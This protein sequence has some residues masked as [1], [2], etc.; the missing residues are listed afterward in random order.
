MRY[1]PIELQGEILRYLPEIALNA[2]SKTCKRNSNLATPLL[3]RKLAINVRLESAT[4]SP[5]QKIKS[6]AAN[7]WDKCRYLRSIAITCR[8]S[9]AWLLKG[10]DMLV[11][12]YILLIHLP[13]TGLISFAWDVGYSF[14]PDIVR[15][16]CW[17]SALS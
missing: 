15:H 6:Y 2:L 10:R 4:R 9:A 11:S 16:L 17:K 7:S 8:E 14:E 1:L 3:Y 5:S 13:P 12:L